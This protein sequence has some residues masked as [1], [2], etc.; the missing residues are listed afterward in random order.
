MPLDRTLAILGRFSSLKPRTRPTLSGVSGGDIQQFVDA[1]DTV[2]GELRP[3]WGELG[4]AGPSH[5]AA[6]Q[7]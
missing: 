7:R 2:V 1:V 4:R 5:R 3:R 6:G